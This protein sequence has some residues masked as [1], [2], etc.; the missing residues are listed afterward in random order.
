[1]TKGPKGEP[2]VAVTP[3]SKSIDRLEKGGRANTGGDPY[4]RYRGQYSK[5]PPP[6]NDFDFGGFGE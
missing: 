6:S 2:P 1:M 3:K 4:D 5:N